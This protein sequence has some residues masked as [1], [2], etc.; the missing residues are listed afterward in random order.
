MFFYAVYTMSAKSWRPDS[1]LGDNIE[2]DQAT[3]HLDDRA[4]QQLEAKVSEGEIVAL[5]PRDELGLAS[6]APRVEKRESSNMT[7]RNS[8]QK[9]GKDNS[10]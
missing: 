5:T 2:I 8:S 3:R 4:V 10:A 9:V 1:S 6:I 7:G